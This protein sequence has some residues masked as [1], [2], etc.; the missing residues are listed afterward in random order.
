MVVIFTPEPGLLI[1]LIVNLSTKDLALISLDLHLSFSQ[2]NCNP[3]IICVQKT[4]S[5]L[6]PLQALDYESVIFMDTLQMLV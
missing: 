6:L 1:D 4:I 2:P 5:K 3:F